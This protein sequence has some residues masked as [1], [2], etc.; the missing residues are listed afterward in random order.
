MWETRRPKTRRFL[1]QKK[2]KQS[3]F[4]GITDRSEIFVLAVSQPHKSSQSSGFVAA[5]LFRN[6]FAS[7]NPNPNLMPIKLTNT[8]FRIKIVNADEEHLIIIGNNSQIKYN[9]T[10]TFIY[11]AYVF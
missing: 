3:S 6:R 11:V 10:I 7:H 4:L 2:K 9:R 8:V 1:E 5:F